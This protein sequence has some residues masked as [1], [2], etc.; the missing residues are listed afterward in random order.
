MK[1]TKEGAKAEKPYKNTIYQT[2]PPDFVSL[3]S[4]SIQ[5]LL[6]PSPRI[7]H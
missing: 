2:D 1:E 6:P 7:S 4:E 5:D 3:L